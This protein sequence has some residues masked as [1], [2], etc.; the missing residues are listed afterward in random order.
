MGIFDGNDIKF[1]G[2][3]QPLLKA[4]QTELCVTAQ[5][6]S[7]K[8]GERMFTTTSEFLFKPEE[9]ETIKEK[10]M[11]NAGVFAATP[12]VIKE[13]FEYMLANM[14]INA[15]FGSEQLSLNLYCYSEK[16]PYRDMGEIYNFL[17]I[18]L[19]RSM[20]VTYQAEISKELS[21]DNGYTYE[22]K[23]PEIT[24]LTFDY[25]NGKKEPIAVL[26]SHQKHA[27]KVCLRLKDTVT[28][29]TPLSVGD[30]TEFKI[31]WV[32]GSDG[33]YWIHSEPERNGGSATYPIQ[34]KTFD[35][36]VE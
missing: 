33:H 7:L 24:D 15:A 31:V 25:P 22:I 32:K 13:L 3:I 21:T 34:S 8:Q 30:K 16:H 36:A 19:D 12:T 17:P 4:A 2:S 1:L 5:K 14:E 23:N 10:P 9:Y 28:S 35:S 26:H 20:T 18:F 6:G 27:Q 29:P 11:I